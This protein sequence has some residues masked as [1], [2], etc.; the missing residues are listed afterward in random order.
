MKVFVVHRAQA[1]FSR[2]DNTSSEVV[3][4]YTDIGIA[5]KV[6]LLARGTWKEVDVDYIWPGIEQTAS[7]FGIKLY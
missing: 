3:G 7:E 1:G 2:E 6:A 4:V 5:K